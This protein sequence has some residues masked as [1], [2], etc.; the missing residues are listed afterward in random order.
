EDRAGPQPQGREDPWS[1][2][3]G[4]A[5]R[6]RRRGDRMKRREFI[7]MLGGAAAWPV[8]ARAQQRA[9]PVIGYLHAGS[10]NQ[11]E[12]VFRRTLADVG[13]VENKN[14]T[15]EYRYA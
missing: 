3:P 6:P 2:H 1:Q 4:H 10:P 5:A 7:T 8:A 13:F 12:A 14:A 9:M 11:P 15:I